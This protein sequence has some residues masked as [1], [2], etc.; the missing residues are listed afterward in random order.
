MDEQHDGCRKKCVV[1]AGEC[2]QNEAFKAASHYFENS[3]SSPAVYSTLIKPIEYLGRLF[4]AWFV[5]KTYCMGSNYTFQIELVAYED[6]YLPVDLLDKIK[7]WPGSLDLEMQGNKDKTDKTSATQPDPDIQQHKDT[8]SKSK[9]GR[10]SSN[11][12]IQKETKSKE[13]VDPMS[14]QPFP[15]CHFHA[16]LQILKHLKLNREEDK[17]CDYIGCSKKSCWLCW[18]ILY[19]DARYQTQGSHFKLYHKWAIPFD[20]TPANSNI[21][22]GLISA[23]SDMFHRIQDKVVRGK[24]LTN[25]TAKSESS[26]RI[27]T[28][29]LPVADTPDPAIA[30]SEGIPDPAAP[31]DDKELQKLLD[32]DHLTIPGRRPGAAQIDAIHL[33]GNQSSCEAPHIVKV[34]LYHADNS[35]GS[36]EVFLTGMTWNEDFLRPAFQLLT[37]RIKNALDQNIFENKTIWR[38]DYIENK[39][40]FYRS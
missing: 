35:P 26:R 8:T 40:V 7:S 3:F 27:T 30:V 23:Y 11:I 28:I 13:K 33:P 22:E 6:E 19:H 9:G 16:E 21:T 32:E 18:K 17:Y 1:A 4:S 29:A 10:V 37:G 34:D 25:Y 5:F 2:R 20:F 31:L 12:Q 14:S 36:N 38:R 39:S 24:A 15:D